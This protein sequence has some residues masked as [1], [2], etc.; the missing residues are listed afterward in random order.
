[1]FRSHIKMASHNNRPHS[2]IHVGRILEAR[3]LRKHV[4]GADCI[5]DNDLSPN[6]LN[7]LLNP[8]LF[9]TGLRIRKSG[10]KLLMMFELHIQFRGV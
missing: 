1:M 9:I 2:L 8:G 3:S 6:S 10:L 5:I 7:I 4:E